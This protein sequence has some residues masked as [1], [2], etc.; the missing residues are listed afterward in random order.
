MK[1]LLTI[2]FFLNTFFS[3]GQIPIPFGTG[4]VVASPF[5]A[6]TVTYLNAESAIGKTFTTAQQ[7]SIDRFIQ[8]LKGISN[9]RYT[10]NNVLSRIK[11]LYPFLTGVEA[12]D[13]INMVNPGTYNYTSTGSPTYNTSTLSVAFN[14]TSQY[15]NTTH[16]PNGSVTLAGSDFTGMCYHRQDVHT[17]GNAT[18]GETG[19]GN[20][21]MQI[22]TS[23]GFTGSLCGSLLYSG[24]YTQP[25]NTWWWMSWSNTTTQNGYNNVTKFVATTNTYGNTPTRSVFIGAFDNGSP[26]GYGGPATIDYYIQITSTWTDAEEAGVYNATKALKGSFAIT[27]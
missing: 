11:I 19:G 7:D 26:A 9:P 12:Y 22:Y 8:D 21:Y 15:L 25:S 23:A 5:Q 27:W 16:T 17:D 14:G 3:S 4:K 1:I 24:A 2:L 10:T 18:V 20:S 13:Q 6:E